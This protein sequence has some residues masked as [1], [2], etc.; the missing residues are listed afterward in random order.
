M[1]LNSTTTALLAVNLFEHH[2]TL[3]SIIATLRGIAGRC[4]WV[5]GLA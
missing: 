1:N 5:G 3:R 2:G 4:S